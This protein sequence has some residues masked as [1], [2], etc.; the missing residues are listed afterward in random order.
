MLLIGPNHFLKAWSNFNFEFFCWVKKTI[1]RT[2]WSTIVCCLL[3]ANNH[4]CCIV[5]KNVLRLTDTQEKGPNART[6][7]TT[8]QYVSH[9][10]K[11]TV[12]SLSL[13]VSLSLSL[14]L[15]LALF[16][17][18]HSQICKWISDFKCGLWGFPQWV[19]NWKQLSGGFMGTM[20][21]SKDLGK[22]FSLPM[23]AK[24]ALSTTFSP[25]SF[26]TN[27]NEIEEKPISAWSGCSSQ[28]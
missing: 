20:S 19:S 5:L 17:E 9:S 8:L 4:S 23:R 15:A 16:Y 27:S 25:N 21:S 28:I 3:F 24:Y 12:S 7:R 18:N 6:C 26:A 10:S 11:E 1:S 14:S 13:S 2:N 22:K